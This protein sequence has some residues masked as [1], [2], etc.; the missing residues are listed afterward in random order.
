MATCW[1]NDS[2]FSIPYNRPNT[3]SFR[4]RRKLKSLIDRDAKYISNIDAWYDDKV[5]FYLKKL[6]DQNLYDIV[7]VEYVYLSKALMCFPRKVLKVI[8]THDV[9][10][11]RH[12][13]YLKND[14]KYNWFSTTAAQE[15]KGFKR[16]D[17]IVAIQERE[18]V[19]FSRLTDKKI[20]TLGHTVKVKK[21]VIGPDLKKSILFI[22]SGNQSNIDAITYFM[23][24]IF[25]R[26]KEHV[27]EATLL[28]AGPVCRVMNNS[29]DGIEKLGEPNDLDGIYDKADIVV[30]PIRF[31]TGLKIKNIE[32]LG[33]SKPLVTSSIGAE[34][35][36]K[37]IQSAFL[38]ADD[39]KAFSDTVIRIIREPT[40]YRSLSK[41]GYDF[42]V[43]WNIA[44]VDALQEIINTKT[45]P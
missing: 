33:Y 15:R 29:G 20:I 25:P 14:G 2:F 34:G 39:E 3:L 35:M 7:F 43:E 21:K 1:G 44:Q 11:D 36:E 37:G 30:N 16:A 38:V 4:I 22:G 42:A 8:D 45:R 17:I 19:F 6:Y 10:T 12:K 28:I 32:A 26:I 23:D 41:K 5:D 40:L 9:M 24:G 18:K 31:G 13:I 27:P